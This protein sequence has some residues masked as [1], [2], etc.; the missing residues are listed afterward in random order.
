[1]ENGSIV[2]KAR[3]A[4]GLSQTEFAGHLEIPVRTLQQWEQ[5]RRN[6]PDYVLKLILFKLEADGLARGFLKK[7]NESQE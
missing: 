7:L 6:L 2:K 5:G 4:T 3:K 1:M